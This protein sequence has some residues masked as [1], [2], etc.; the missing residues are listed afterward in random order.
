MSYW[1]ASTAPSTSLASTSQQG[2]T[3]S[4][5]TKK[6]CQILHSPPPYRALSVD[7]PQVRVM[8]SPRPLLMNTLFA[9]TLASNR[10]LKRM[11]WWPGMKQQVEQY[12]STCPE[13]QKSK[14]SSQKAA[15]LMMP[16]AT[17]K[18]PWLSV[19][20]DFIVQLPLT[21]GGYDA[22]AVFVDRFSKMALLRPRSTTITAEGTAHL[23]FATVFADHGM[24]GDLVTDR[25]SLS[26]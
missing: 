22:I 25:D 8:H 14:S 23:L 4:L 13:C 10:A 17:P 12:V 21:N 24:P 3:R 11:F 5:S 19:G 15:G 2:I 16:L 20:M 26:S 9:P 1:T 7:C 6:I 18:G